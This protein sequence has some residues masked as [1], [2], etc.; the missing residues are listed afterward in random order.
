MVVHSRKRVFDQG[1]VFAGTEQ[2]ADGQIVTLGH[3]MFPKP[4][5]VGVK[6]ADVLVAELVHL[7]LNQDMALEDAMVEDQVHEAAGVSND[8]A[9]LLGFQAETMAEFQ[10][11]V[12]QVR[13]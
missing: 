8:N 4:R 1:L 10:Q 3:H 5:H 6:L 7:E 11:K 12:P 2:K 13:H 9:F